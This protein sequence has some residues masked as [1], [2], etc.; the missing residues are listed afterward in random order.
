MTNYLEVEFVG[1]PLDGQQG[2][3]PPEITGA[4][5][6]D[7]QPPMVARADMY[8]GHNDGVP[9]IQHIVYERRVNPRDEGVLWLYDY[10]PGSER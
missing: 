1:G 5:P 6:A 2:M 9:I 10:V 4:G 7:W 3:L 8:V